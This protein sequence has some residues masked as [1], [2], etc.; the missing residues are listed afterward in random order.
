VPPSRFARFART[1]LVNDARNGGNKRSQPSRIEHR[2]NDGSCRI[3]RSRR[4]VLRGQAGKRGG[5][6]SSYERGSY[7]TAA[8]RSPLRICRLFAS[9]LRRRSRLIDRRRLRTRA[10]PRQTAEANDCDNCSPAFPFRTKA[11]V[12]PSP[13]PSLSLSLLRAPRHA[14]LASPSPRARKP[15]ELVAATPRIARVVSGGPLQHPSA[16]RERIPHSESDFRAAIEMRKERAAACVCG[17]VASSDDERRGGE[18]GGGKSG[19]MEIKVSVS[20]REHTARH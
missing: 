17:C 13:S 1:I 18:G 20:G 19:E 10:R 5:A 12:S 2:K 14:R 4:R 15:S 11:P 16:H 8:K 6:R 9:T 7:E 3:I